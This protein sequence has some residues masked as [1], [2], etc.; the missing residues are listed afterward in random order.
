MVLFPRLRPNLESPTGSLSLSETRQTPLIPSISKRCEYDGLA[1]RYV[2]RIPGCRG[3]GI[4]TCE[5]SRKFEQDP[6]SIV[7]LQKPDFIERKKVVDAVNRWCEENEGKPEVIY[8]NE[9][10]P[11]LYDYEI[12]RSSAKRLRDRGHLIFTDMTLTRFLLVMCFGPSR[13][14]CGSGLSF[15]EDYA[16]ITRDN[17]NRFMSLLKYLHHDESKPNL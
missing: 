12:V 15:E 4:S 7:D 5:V 6:D 2:L 13:S 3:M 9:W 11:I 17:A 1:D 16:A 10:A 8:R 14:L